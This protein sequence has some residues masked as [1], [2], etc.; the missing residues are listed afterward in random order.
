MAG[1]SPDAAS[2]TF[3]GTRPY[4]TTY[5]CG[6]GK[7][8]SIGSTE[9][10]LW[11]NFCDA[12][13]RPD[14]KGAELMPGEAVRG[15]R[16]EQVEAKREV[17]ALLRTKPRDEWYDL[18]TKADV[19]VGKVY[20][21]HEVFE[22]PQVRHRDMAVDLDVDGATALNPGVAIKLSDTPGA[23]RFPTPPAGS[24]HR[25]DPRIPRLRSAPTSTPCEPPAPSSRPGESN[26]SLGQL[27]QREVTPTVTHVNVRTRLACLVAAPWRMSRWSRQFTREQ[28]G[29]AQGS[30][31][32]HP[33]T[34]VTTLLSSDKCC[35]RVAA[36]GSTHS[37]SVRREPMEEDRR[38]GSVRR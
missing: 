28:G 31:R 27:A 14:L 35:S 5:E 7:L 19:C 8:L 11:H 6:D 34:G 17:A 20:D 4:Y 32:T 16:P 33:L 26:T 25:G 21:P 29:L 1:P 30:V 22:D 18:L 36:D 37:L 9:P 23:V 10:H 24:P 3:D 15:P 12:V 38:L 13:D 2:G